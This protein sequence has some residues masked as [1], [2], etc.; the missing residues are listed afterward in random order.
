M[1]IPPNIVLDLNN[2]MAQ[3]HSTLEF[4]TQ[5]LHL[6]FLLALQCLD[7]ALM[8]PMGNVYDKFLVEIPSYLMEVSYKEYWEF[9]V[10][11]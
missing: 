5:E 11:F 2:V 3:I 1:S 8:D 9:K 4:S 7:G 10:L 6:S